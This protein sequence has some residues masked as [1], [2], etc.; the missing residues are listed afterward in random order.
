MS[1]INN[2]KQKHLKQSRTGQDL[3][4]TAYADQV[5]PPGKFHGFEMEG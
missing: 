1:S 4:T 3:H 5:V 2:Q